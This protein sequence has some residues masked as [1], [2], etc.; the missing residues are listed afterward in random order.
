MN[1]RLVTSALLKNRIR[2]G[3]SVLGIGIGIAAVICTGAIGAATSA[4]IERQIDALGEDLLWIRAGSLDRGG[5]R[6]GS[7]GARTLRADDARALAGEVTG[8]STCSPVASGR[9]QLIAGASNWNTR[10]QGVLPSFFSIRRRVPIA[11]T[12]FTEA[13]VSE[14]ARV[15]V[16]GAAVAQ[17]LFEGETRWAGRSGWAAFRFW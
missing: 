9:E 8:I 17:N 2:T 6:S 12:L 1:M 11:G 15:V 4:R 10:Y 14:H 5:F 7:G 13:D 16:L 3:L